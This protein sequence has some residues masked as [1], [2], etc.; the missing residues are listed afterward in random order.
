MPQ[1]T[2]APLF[3]YDEVCTIGSSLPR[4]DSMLEP[5]SPLAESRENPLETGALQPDSSE[6]KPHVPSGPP[7]ASPVEI[8]ESKS[9]PDKAA[10]SEGKQRTIGGWFKTMLKR[11]GH[12]PPSGE[13]PQTGTPPSNE[14]PST[15]THAQRVKVS[16]S[17]LSVRARLSD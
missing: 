5:P 8:P 6:A 4:V 13:S 11:T 15:I 16:F 14:K 17:F 12:S 1:K 2:S 9:N 10:T 3:N 7:M